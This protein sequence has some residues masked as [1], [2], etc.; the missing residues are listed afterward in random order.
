MNIKEKKYNEEILSK[1]E[2]ITKDFD[3]IK[4]QQGMS[5]KKKVRYNNPDDEDKNFI[6]DSTD[7]IIVVRTKELRIESKSS[8]YI[9]LVFNMPKTLG[10]YSASV[11]V[12][13]KDNNKIEEILRFHI[14]VVP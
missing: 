14:L 12:T 5:V 10:T 13:N 2:D 4:I 9:R 3:L 8:E 11:V 6:V 7:D 1:Y